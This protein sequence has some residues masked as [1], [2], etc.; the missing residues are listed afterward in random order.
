MGRMTNILTGIII[1]LMVVV[2]AGGLYLLLTGS[3]DTAPEAAALPTLAELPS[4]TPLPATSTS[5]PTLP[6]TFTPTSPPTL[7]LAPSLTPTFTPSVTSTIT[8]T[9]AP[10]ATPAITDTFTPSPTFTATATSSIP[11]ATGTATRSPFPFAVRGGQAVLTQNIYNQQGCAFQAISGQV[12]NEQGAGVNGIQIIVTEPGGVERIGVSGNATIYGDGGYEVPV[13]DQINGRT[14]IVQL[15]TSA[16]TELSEPY[17]VAFPS[18]CD[19]NV[20]LIYWSQTRPF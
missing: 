15:R 10:T 3:N 17:T 6:P 13:D 2:L 1:V 12:I 19:Q 5:R 20:A 11:T 9:P 14:Y 8:D 18:N 4:I 7:T 16:G